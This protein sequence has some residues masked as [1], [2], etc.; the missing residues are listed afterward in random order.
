MARQRILDIVN[1]DHAALNFLAYR[2]GWINANTEFD[3]PRLG[4]FLR[5]RLRQQRVR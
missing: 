1:T 2:V 3:N 5:Y 4:E